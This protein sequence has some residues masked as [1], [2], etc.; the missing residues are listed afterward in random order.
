M[1]ISN[2]I[3]GLVAG[4]AFHYHFKMGLT[5]SIIVGVV[6]FAVISLVT[7]G[8]MINLEGFSMP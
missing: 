6:A 5:Y 2:L 8:L 4:A 3:L 1:L 7:E